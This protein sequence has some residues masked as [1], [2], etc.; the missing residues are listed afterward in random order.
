M[1]ENMEKTEK[2]RKNRRKINAMKATGIV[3]RI[4]DLGRV[5]VPKEIRRTLR[6]REGD[7]LEIF[8]DKEGEII[9]KKYSPIGELSAFAKQY[10]ESLSQMLGCLAGICD[11]DQVVAAAGNGKK[12]LQDEDITRELGEFLKERKTQN[13]KAGEKRYVPVVSKTEPYSQEVISPILCAGDVI[14]AVLLLNMDQKDLFEEREICLVEYT[15]K[16]L[17]KQMEQ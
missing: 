10:A 16:V 1:L 7:P 11:M 4:D 17:G 5:V 9:L 14:G 15:A 2:N 8:T 3:R 6:I 13:A 12:E